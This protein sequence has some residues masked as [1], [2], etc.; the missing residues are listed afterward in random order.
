MKGR[1]PAAQ[2]KPFLIMFSFRKQQHFHCHLSVL[3]Q[4]LRKSQSPGRTSKTDSE[5][6][7]QQCKPA[8]QR[9]V[10]ATHSTPP[11]PG[12]LEQCS[13]AR[14]ELPPGALHIYPLELRRGGDTEGRGAYAEAH[15]PSWQGGEG[16]WQT[17]GRRGLRQE[18]PEALGV[19]ESE[20]VQ[21]HRERTE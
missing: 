8:A 4:R 14:R 15:H 9:Q 6:P 18:S 2:G 13:G 20:N 11:S 1:T 17:A 16:L 3:E 12:L 21:G 5:S 7:L 10:S 19:T